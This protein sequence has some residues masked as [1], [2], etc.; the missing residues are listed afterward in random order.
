ML[1]FVPD[2]NCDLMGV[3]RGGSYYD[4]PSLFVSGFW[5]SDILEA[6]H[7]WLATTTGQIFL[8]ISI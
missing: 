6:L 8:A 5:V 2:Q 3:P 1:F 7:V 4:L